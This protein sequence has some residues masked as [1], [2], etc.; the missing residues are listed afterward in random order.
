[1]KNQLI[2][3][4]QQALLLPEIWGK[5]NPLRSHRLLPTVDGKLM[6][7]RRALRLLGRKKLFFTGNRN[8]LA[9]AMMSSGITVLDLSPPLYAPLR[10]LLAGAIDTD[11]LCQ[12]RPEPPPLPAT[13]S[14]HEFLDAVNAFLRKLLRK[15]LPCL[16]APGL[17]R[18]DLLKIALPAPLR[19]APFFF[20]QYFIAINPAGS[21]FQHL[22]SMYKLNRS[23]AV[24]KFLRRLH[25]DRLLDG[26]SGTAL[27]K[28]AARRLLRSWS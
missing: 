28:K 8:P 24:F 15:P 6:S 23:L 16:L 26:F 2:Q 22:S 20:P 27:L 11:M 21:A 19:P 25:S 9:L 12:L 3:L 13:D 4:A 10:T 14:E 7:I 5:D 18:V 17:R 1:M